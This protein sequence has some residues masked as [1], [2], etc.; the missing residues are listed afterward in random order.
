MKAFLKRH[1]LIIGISL[2]FLYTW[3]IDLSNSGI[4]PFQFP[5]ALTITLGW[6]FIFVSL[7]MT[8]LTLGKE[9]MVR[10]FKRFFLW[11]VDW[12]WWLVAILLLPVLRFIAIPLTT[13]LTGIPADYS[14]PMIRDIVPL[15]APLLALVVP[16][17][18]FEILTN[19]EEI[20]WRGYV[21]P[22]LQAKHSALVASLIVGAIWGV[23][24][25]PKFLGTG[26]GVERSFLWFVIA[27]VALSVLYTWLYNSTRGSLLLVT[28]F[29]A[30]GNT[31]GVFMPAKFA[32][33][34]GILFNLEIVFFVIAAIVVTLVAGAER[35]SRTEEKQIQE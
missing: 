6:G 25:L 28:L 35:L 33:A 17:I 27:H 15:D 32:V 12:K 14:R 16:W 19:G 3:T 9:E 31:F 2:M 30:S 11:R 10:L 8:W 24:H 34:G 1:S 29:H 7:F 22:R 5:F 13:L 4:L 20:G 21:L 23:W 26:A 18:L